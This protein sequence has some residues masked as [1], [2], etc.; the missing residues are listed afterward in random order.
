VNV[1]VTAALAALVLAQGCWTSAAR[2]LPRTHTRYDGLDD[3]A[4]RELGVAREKIDAGRLEE[5]R[6]AL[7]ALCRSHPDSIVL[8]MWLQEAEIAALSAGA[9]TTLDAGAASALDELRER[10][11]ERAA[12]E[13]SVARLVLAARLEP[14]EAHAEALLAAAEALDPRCAWI[15]YARAF[16]GA[17]RSAWDDV[18]RQLEKAE[19]LDPGHMPT[20][21]LACWMLARG[22]RVREAI[23]SLETWVDRA[24]EDVR[25]DRRLVLEAELDLAVLQLL[26]GDAG[27][28]RSLLDDLESRG[29][30][31]ARERM[32]EAATREALGDP[33]S[34][35]D[36]AKAAEELAP[37]EILPVVQQALLEELWLNDPAAAETAWTRVLALAKS[38]GELSGMLERVR[39][40][41]RL[42]RFQVARA[43]GGS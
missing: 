32:V 15:P 42:E 30:L 21:W 29:V 23:V 37:G 16:L 33:Q 4:T 2:S 5:A 36:A 11:A 9:P 22:G 10:Y 31:G 24:R 35:L 26:D 20:R 27:R 40:R 17:R 41:A 43:K 34:A 18:R 14:D 1:R 7:S 6:V 8:G 12:E 39:A 19:K 38:S 13:P 3:L 28:A 25:V